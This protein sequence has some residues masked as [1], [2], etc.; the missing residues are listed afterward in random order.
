MAWSLSVQRTVHHMLSGVS[1]N[2]LPSFIGNLAVPRAC[3][4]FQSHFMQ[5][6]VC[7]N[8]HGVLL[9]RHDMSHT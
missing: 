5:E 3:Q 4:M 7:L 8:F 1:P 6:L 9:D 2:L